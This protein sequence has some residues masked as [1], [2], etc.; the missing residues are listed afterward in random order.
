MNSGTA[1]FLFTSVITNFMGRRG[2]RLAAICKLKG[3]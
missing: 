2:M 3:R 1:D